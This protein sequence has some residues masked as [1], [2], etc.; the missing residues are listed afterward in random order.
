MEL[1]LL[2]KL[3]IIL[4]VDCDENHQNCCLE[5]SNFKSKMQQIRCR[6]RPD[7]AGELTALPH[8]P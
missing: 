3:H 1:S 5:T 2:F 7:L 6:L 4:S 8:T